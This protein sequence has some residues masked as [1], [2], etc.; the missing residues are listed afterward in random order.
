MASSARS[1]TLGLPR[2]RLSRVSVSG[3]EYLTDSGVARAT[4]TRIAFLS[5][6][7]GVSKP[8]FDTLNVG[9]NTADDPSSV[10]NNR[11]R[12][13]GALG[14]DACADELVSPKQVHG[15]LVLVV[16]DP[17]RL[18]LARAQ[19]GADAIVCLVPRVPVL[20][21]FADCTPVVMVVPDGSFCVAHAGWR[22]AYAQIAGKALRVLCERTGTSPAQANVY[23]GPHIGACCYEVS[24]DL[25]ARFVARFGPS[26]DAGGGHLSLSSAIICDLLRAGVDKARIVEDETCTRDSTDRYF[27]YR[28]SGGECGRHGALVC[29]L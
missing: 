9:S 10:A 15:D 22:G 27:S 24:D 25:L 3:I 14:A 20:L 7:G 17:E 5:R 12:A 23:I 1:E 11:L 13:L 2:P 19:T 21:C 29:R 28:A 6:S 8:P 4:G 26:V 18:P 16:D